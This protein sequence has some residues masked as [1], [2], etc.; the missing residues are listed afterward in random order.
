MQHSLELEPEPRSVTAARRWMRGL[1]RDVGHEELIDTA[2]L[3]TSELVTNAVL[4]AGTEI[5]VVVNVEGADVLVEIQDGSETGLLPPVVLPEEATSDPATVPSV[6]NGLFILSAVTR[7]WGV[8]EEPGQGKAVWFVPAPTS[9]DPQLPSTPTNGRARGEG[10]VAVELLRAPVIMLWNEMSRCR[11]LARELSLLLLSGQRNS[12]TALAEQFLHSYVTDEDG[13]QA[14]HDAYVEGRTT[15]TVPI[16]VR[17][18]RAGLVPGFDEL[19]AR[20][21]ELSR[22]GALLTVPA[23]AP[24]R[25]VRAWVLG[26]IERQVTGVP[27]QPWRS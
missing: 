21:D 1:M 10:I 7:S 25:A 13:W 24:G 26:E 27:A 19:L 6:G 12:L 16:R 11:D 8:R 4:H 20:L 18:A 15:A 17:R 9:G 3:A 22:T 5:S 14:L 23:P 2:E